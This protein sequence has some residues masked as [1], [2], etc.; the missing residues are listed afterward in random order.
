MSIGVGSEASGLWHVT[1]NRD[2]GDSSAASS[3]GFLKAACADLPWSSRNLTS[4][5]LREC[6]GSYMGVPPCL[7]TQVE[8][9]QLSQARE[10]MHTLH[11][12]M[13]DITPTTQDTGNIIMHSIA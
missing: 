6:T 8:M 13:E 9:C 12:C 1:P 7:Q 5:V 2:V 3:G 11:G 10:L 4:L